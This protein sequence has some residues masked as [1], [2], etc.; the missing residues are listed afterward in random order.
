MKYNQLNGSIEC[1]VEEEPMDEKHALYRF[2]VR[3]TGIGMSE[4]FQKRMFELFSQ[5]EGEKGVSALLN[6]APGTD[7]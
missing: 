2:I 5:E 1:R 7:R 4:A 3:D 6:V